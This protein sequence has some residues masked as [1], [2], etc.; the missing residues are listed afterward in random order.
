MKTNSKDKNK[1]II[2]DIQIVSTLN[3]RLYE[4]CYFRVVISRVVTQKKQK[5][6]CVFISVSSP[7]YRRH[8]AFLLHNFFIGQSER[9][10]AV[11]RQVIMVFQARS[12]AVRVYP[13]GI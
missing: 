1:K 9:P 10:G 11:A 7:A 12:L 3:P 4:S 8:C 5:A 2:N 13:F 6:L